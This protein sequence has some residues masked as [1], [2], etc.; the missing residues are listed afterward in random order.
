MRSFIIA[1]FFVA[2]LTGVFSQSVESMYNHVPEI[3]RSGLIVQKQKI[4][5][6]ITLEKIVL[7]GFDSKI[8][9]YHYFNSS[10]NNASYVI[11]LHGLGD[12]KEDWVNPSE[13]YLDWGGNISVMK[14]SLLSLG[15]NLI[16]PDVKYHV[17]RSYEI[18]FRPA[19]SLPP[20]I[21]QNKG[22]AQL[23]KTMITST[24][25]D[26]RIIMDYVQQRHDSADQYFGVIGYSLGG[27]LAI[28]LSMFDDRVSRAVGC[29]APVNLPARGLEEFNWPGKLCKGR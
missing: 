27:N 21:S 8:P 25:K 29:V 28:L 24:I 14:D 26:L 17:E 9:F 6:L 20:A 16:I 18:G 19:V 15:Y 22:D 2:G 3:D 12:S 10:N 1:C 4:D 23:F 5:S 7:D 11:L 13:P